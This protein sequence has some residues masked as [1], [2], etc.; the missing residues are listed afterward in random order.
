MKRAG[1]G[2]RAFLGAALGSGLFAALARR[3]A[4]AAEERYLLIYWIKGGWDPTFVF[5][6]HFES[7]VIHRDPLSTAGTS[8]GIIYADAESRPSVRA[9][10]SRWGERTVVVNG[11]AVGSISH[12]GCTR[13]MLTSS[14]GTGAPDFPTRIAEGTSLPHVVISG[15]RFPGELGEVVLSVNGTLVSTADGTLPVPR[16][17]ASEARIQEWLASEAAALPDSRRKEQYIDGLTRLPAL[18]AH[19]SELHGATSINDAEVFET[20]ANVLGAGLAR[21]VMIQGSLPQ[22]GQWDS[23]IQ[24]DFLQNSAYEWA[25]GRLNDLLARLALTAAPGGGVLSDHTTVMV[26]SEMGRSPVLNGAEGKDH[27][28]WTSAMIVGAGVGGGRTLGGTDSGFAGLAADPAT[29]EVTASG[30]AITPAS[31]AAGVLTAFDLDSS[32]AYPGVEPFTA[33]F[34]G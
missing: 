3:S 4:R 5:D 9:F 7:D 34:V 13:L 33:P 16:N 23:H 30:D 22:F 29:G 6:P 18:H 26:L 19:A 31:L 32:E 8:G 21:S 17:E 20:V 25:F 27:W 11:I 10:F 28:P 15:P 2:R 12:D 24:N 14:R 1:L